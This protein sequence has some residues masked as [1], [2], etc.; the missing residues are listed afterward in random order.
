MNIITLTLSPAFDVHCR[1][2]ELVLHKE[3]HATVTD[4]CAGGKGVNV[5][6]APAAFG[7]D[8]TAVTV[9]G[10][11][12]HKPFE[13][14]ME[15]DGVSLL[16]VFT[17]GSIR[18]NLTVHTDDGRETRISFG[19]AAVS[20]SV[21][22]EAQDLLTRLCTDGSVLAVMGSIPDGVSVNAVKAMLRSLKAQGVR[23]V[24]D[25]RSFALND[26]IEVA[27]FLIKPNEQ[28]IAA[29]MNVDAD[30]MRAIRLAAEQ[31]YR[32]GVENV[33]ISLGARGALLVSE[34]GCHLA[35]A[36]TVSPLSTI[37][38]GDSAVAGFLMGLS[39]GEDAVSC[40]RRAVALGSAACLTSGTRPPRKEDAESLLPR[41]TITP[42]E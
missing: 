16:P 36:P 24:I 8:S 32:G 1:T 20:A 18:E 31:L 15:R 33:M 25:S 23:I 5:S 17:E 7:I 22:Q 14:E 6:R 21:F 11:E 3:N 27:P 37:G 30:D 41:V 40:L 35:V 10:K 29:Y 26:L 19:G 39:L 28:E 42:L 9:L 12:N 34:S 38:A 2:G 13:E 4:R